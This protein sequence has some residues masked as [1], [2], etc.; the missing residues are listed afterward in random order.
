MMT[1]VYAARRLLEHGSLSFLDFWTITGW[2]KDDAKQALADLLKAGEVTKIQH[3]GLVLG[4]A[5]KKTR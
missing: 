5:L 3:N 1:K 4:Y 2:T